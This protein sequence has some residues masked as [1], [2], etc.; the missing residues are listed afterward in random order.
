MPG[1]Y[2]VHL[3][4]SVCVHERLRLEILVC[5]IITWENYFSVVGMI[6]REG[7]HNTPYLGSSQKGLMGVAKYIDGEGDERFS[8]AYDGRHKSG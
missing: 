3:C 7:E 5:T 2:Y 8:A 6:Q 4:N 1:P